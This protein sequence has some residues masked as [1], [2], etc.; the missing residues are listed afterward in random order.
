LKIKKKQK[1]KQSNKKTKK[2][3]ITKRHLPFTVVSHS[4]RL[5]PFSIEYNL[6]NLLQV[7]NYFCIGKDV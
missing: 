5:I 7:Y 3:P 1:K 6:K 4:E 2:K